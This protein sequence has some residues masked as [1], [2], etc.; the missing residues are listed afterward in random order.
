MKFT[1]RLCWFCFA[2]LVSPAVYA[3]GATWLLRA[4][5]GVATQ[6]R[7][8]VRIPGDDGDKFSLTD[9]AGNGPFP[10]VRLEWMYDV[11]P[12]HQFRVLL[13]PFEYTETGSLQTPIRFV[14]KTFQPGVAT[15]A[16]YRF[17]SYRF[18]YR[19]LF[20]QGPRWQ[21]RG[22]VTAKIRDAEISLKQGTTRAAKDD[23][24]VVPLISLYGTASLNERWRLILDADGL[25]GPGGRA[26]DLGVFAE[27][28]FAGPWTAGIGYR[29]LEGGADNDAVYNFAWFNY[30]MVT[31]SYRGGQ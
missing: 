1:G 7:N 22:G 26:I 19:Y 5:M 28:E 20:Y 27:Y 30:A 2:L 14:D 24:G 23:L 11:A 31:L 4:E 8:D 25:V 29:T 10:A 17:N 3:D 9:L 15:E 13:A 6:T 21:W 18:S 12:K 16:S